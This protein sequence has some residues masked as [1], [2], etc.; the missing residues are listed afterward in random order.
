MIVAGDVHAALGRPL[1]SAGA[2]LISEA[3]SRDLAIPCNR[4][5]QAV[6]MSSPCCLWAMR[7]Q[8]HK[9]ATTGM[10]QLCFEVVQCLCA[11]W[12]NKG[13][14]NKRSDR[15]L[16]TP[17]FLAP[18]ASDSL[19]FPQNVIGNIKDA[20]SRLLAHRTLGCLGIV[21]ASVRGA[22]YNADLQSKLLKN[23]Q[24]E[25]AAAATS[26]MGSSPSAYALEGTIHI[27]QECIVSSS[28]LT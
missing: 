24:N 15:A 25:R 27:R 10:A 2:L 13:N 20:L 19:Q 28:C 12:H 5:W 4:V 3:T 14:P 1:C 9:T 6:P 17:Q 26:G 23:L 7:G 21:P 8:A 22:N 18:A 11:S 16:H